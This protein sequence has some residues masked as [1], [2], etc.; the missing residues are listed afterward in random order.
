[1]TI[2]TNP[3]Y[4]SDEDNSDEEQDIQDLIADMT[5]DEHD[6]TSQD[7]TNDNMYGVYWTEFRNSTFSI[8]W[9]RQPKKNNT[10]CY[11][12]CANI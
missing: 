5:G 2:L 7:W 3:N 4:S 12:S 1:M 10:C 6:E 9:N 11:Y 8:Y